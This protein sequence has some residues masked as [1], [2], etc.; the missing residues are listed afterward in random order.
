MI[1]VSYKSQVAIYEQIKT[2]I[3]DLILKDVFK[4]DEQ[5]PSVRFLASELLINQNTIQKAYT[6]LERE[7][8]TYTVRGKGSF[9]NLSKEELL[10]KCEPELFHS[11]E[12]AT[13]EL[14]K[15]GI[16]IER[17]MAYLLEYQKKQEKGESLDDKVSERIEV[18]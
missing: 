18:V 11:F 5:L 12:K 6:E 4:K 2:S 9:V 15:A 3:I 1:K 16:S 7:G 8:I 13:D 17:I 14:L 10:A